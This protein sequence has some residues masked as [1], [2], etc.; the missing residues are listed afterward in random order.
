[1]T[2]ILIRLFHLTYLTQDLIEQLN[3]EK[4]GI[5]I[6]K[7]HYNVSCYAYDILL[8]STTPSRLQELIDKAVDY[9]T[10]HSSGFIQQRPHASIL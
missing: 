7:G 1:M 9:T 3:S 2:E 5:I 6:D 8:S 10:I 4:C